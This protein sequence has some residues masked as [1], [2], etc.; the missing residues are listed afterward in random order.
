[1]GKGRSAWGAW[2]DSSRLFEGNDLAFGETGFDLSLEKVRD[3]DDHGAAFERFAGFDEDV[4][5]TLL[6]EDGG[7]RDRENVV[8]G[9]NRDGNAGGHAG[10]DAR[11]NFFEHDAGGVTLDVIAE[12]GLGSDALDLALDLEAGDGVDLDIDLHAALEAGDVGLIDVGIDHH[13]AEVGDREDLGATV[14]S[15]GAGDG[16]AGGDGAGQDGAVEGRHDPGAGE[17]F[18]REGQVFFG[19]FDGVEGDLMI[20]DGRFVALAAGLVG[21]FGEE[22]CLEQFLIPFVVAFGLVHVDA[23]LV[24][25]ELGVLDLFLSGLDLEFEVA[26]VE[27]EEQGALLDL[28]ADVDG[29][30]ADA[31]VDFG[32]NGNL[33]CGTDFAGDSDREV[34]GASF[35]DGGGGPLVGGF[36]GFLGR[37][38]LGG[39]PIDETSSA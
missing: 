13:G 26:V 30:F 29:Q 14:E 35:D 11:I 33:F 3:P 32:A 18:L 38:G 37:F 9:R 21:L 36:G 1:L 7:E 2:R 4:A 34:H 23:G 10:L 17:A 39:S 27:G 24:E 20:L 15:A 6:A 31:T 5:F 25:L 12:G 19:S 8:G 28:V 22:F 16:L